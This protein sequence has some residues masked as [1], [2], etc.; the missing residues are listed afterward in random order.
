MILKLFAKE[1]KSRS[2]SLLKIQVTCDAWHQPK[3]CAGSLEGQERDTKI[4]S[5][6]RLKKDIELLIKAREAK[7]KQSRRRG[8]RFESE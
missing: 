6:K 1:A 7:S 3:T 5:G 2:E 8:L 4:G